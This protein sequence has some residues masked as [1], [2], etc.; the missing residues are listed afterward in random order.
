MHDVELVEE[1]A[2]P[3]P[4]ERADRSRVVRRTRLR[5]LLRRWWP[6]A[7]GVV[8]AVVVAQVVADRQHRTEVG[9]RRETDGVLQA[10]VRPPL[11]ATRWE[12]PDARSLAET[13]VP[14]VGGL[15]A[16]VVTP[17]DG[18]APVFVA[19]DPRTGEEA[20]RVGPGPA[21]EAPAPGGCV[22]AEPAASTVWCLVTE[23]ASRDGEGLPERLVEVGVEEGSTSTLLLAG[24]D[25]DE[26]E[27]QGIAVPVA[28]DDGSAPGLLLVQRLDGTLDGLLAAVDA[29]TGRTLWERAVHRGTYSPLIVLDGVVY[30]DGG[31][32]VWA[33][34]LLTGE[35]HWSTA[36]QLGQ[37][38]T[39]FTDGESLLRTESDPTTGALALS[40]D[41]LGDGH[42][43]WTAP[44]PEGIT[45]V[46]ARAGAPFGLDDAGVV[47]TIG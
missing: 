39:W 42:R 35:E 33:L 26:S 45:W 41:D 13:G 2:G 1:P 21:T 15:I 14:T 38:G 10:T 29:R 20:W 5:R 24:P 34:D 8:T 31:T 19:A 40:A 18:G 37:V 3:G 17:S 36:A 30:G 7:A 22:A 9:H 28:P 47:S 6:L 27:V 4:A 11:G 23:T 12:A 25:A 44:L 46:R 43:A 16:G 32:S